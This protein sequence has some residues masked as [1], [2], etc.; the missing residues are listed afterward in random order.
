MGFLALSSDIRSTAH[1]WDVLSSRIVY[2]VAPTSC[3]LIW[4]LSTYWYVAREQPTSLELLRLHGVCGETKE[5]TPGLGRFYRITLG[6]IKTLS[7]QKQRK[8]A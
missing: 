6:M 8:E 7:S 3:W 5:D 4:G 1:D 2:Y